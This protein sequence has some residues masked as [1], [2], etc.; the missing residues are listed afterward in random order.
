[1]GSGGGGRGLHP[2]PEADRDGV[3]PS[4]RSTK[5]PTR[6]VEEP[7][8]RHGASFKTFDY[9]IWYARDRVFRWLRKKHNRLPV[10]VLN[11][12]YC[13]GVSWPREDGE[14]RVNWKA[15]EMLNIE[16]DAMAEALGLTREER[17][18]ISDEVEKQRLEESS[19]E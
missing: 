9:I 19:K 10:R 17:G 16:V 13:G 2:V 1:M 8:F 4:I 18:K 5:G 3:R 11:A 6:F 12:R 14:S 7:Y 15:V